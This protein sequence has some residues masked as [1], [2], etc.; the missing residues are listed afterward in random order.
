ME[1]RRLQYDPIPLGGGMDLVSTPLE[2]K[3]GRCIVAKNFEPGSN[4]IGYARIGGIERFDGRTRPSQAAYYVVSCAITG[5]VSV[6][7]TITGATSAATAKVI[8][9]VSSSRIIVTKVIGTFVAESFTVG[10]VSQGT[11]TSVIED[12]EVSMALHASYKNLA[13]DEY[14]ADIAKPAGSGAIRGFAELNG[15][16]YC[17]RDN[18]GATACVM[19]KATAS[20][21][22]AVTF[23]R[24]IQFTNAVGE[25][26]EGQTVTGLASGASAVVKRALLRTGTWT[27]SGVGTL[28]FDSVTGAFQNGEA[29]QVGGVTKATSSSADTA[30]T[31]LPGGKFESDKSNFTGAANSDRLYFADG[32]N[33]PGE[34]DGTRWVPIR[35]GSVPSTPKFLRVHR[36]HLIFAASN[37]II[38]SGTGSPYSY[39]ALT[40]AARLLAGQEIT[41]IMSETGDPTTGALTI[42]TQNKIYILYGTSTSDFQLMLHSPTSGAKAYTLQNIGVT[43][44]MD[45][46]GISHIYSAVEFGNFQIKGLTND[47][48]PLI[49]QKQS[50]A[51]ASCIVRKKNQYRVFFSDG[52]GIILQVVGGSG[53]AKA[54]APMFVD[55]SSRSFNV[56]YSIIDATGTERIFS[57]ANDGYVYELDVGTSFD[58]D[59]IQSFLALQFNHSRSVRARNHYLRSVLQ[60]KATGLV[61]LRCGCD[62]GFGRKEIPQTLMTD[63]TVLGSGGYWDAIMTGDFVWDGGSLQEINISTQGIGDGISLIMSGNTDTNP[64]FTITAC[65]P[66]YKSGRFDR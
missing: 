38:T 3:P 30:I 5:S 4:G 17:F 54:I 66:Y 49:D 23:G 18:A 28:V 31:L 7:N 44:F 57:G 48:Q 14:R 47:I 35:T 53:G 45:S 39:T 40:G 52:T 20:G 26:S 8:A 60:L 63:K 42:T 1:M 16:F 65:I 2:V 33:I 22:A 15:D 43:H 37:E 12:A 64:P 51:V 59:N 19:Y 46:Y 61:N 56:V 27:V 36:K 10:G 9:V 34:F 62:F 24:E 25:I 6:G 58:G 13:A 41:G 21:W 55:Y 32:V 29:L 50:M 11:I